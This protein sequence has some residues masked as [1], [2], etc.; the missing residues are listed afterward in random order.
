MAKFLWK[1]IIRRI[2]KKEEFL[3]KK[4]LYFLWHDFQGAVANGLLGAGEKIDRSKVL[5]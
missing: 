4:E 5:E 1:E 2:L 3:R